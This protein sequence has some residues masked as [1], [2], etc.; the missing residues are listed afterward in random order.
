MNSSNE[1][2]CCRTRPFSSKYALITSQHAVCHNSSDISSSSTSTAVGLNHMRERGW[3]TFMISTPTGV[4]HVIVRIH[5][6]RDFNAEL[7]STIE[8]WNREANPGAVRC[9]FMICNSTRYYNAAHIWKQRNR[10]NRHGQVNF[11]WDLRENCISNGNLHKLW[12]HGI[13]L[14][15]FHIFEYPNS[16][17]KDLRQLFSGL[18]VIRGQSLEN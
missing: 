15:W 17:G 3:L 14:F 18:D 9:Q 5:D 8:I 16:L 13:T 10:K 1:S 6:W 12:I 4:H 2:S 7:R 11:R